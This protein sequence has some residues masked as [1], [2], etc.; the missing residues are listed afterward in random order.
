MAEPIGA[1]RVELSAN[2]AQFEKDMGR[3]RIAARN[4]SKSMTKSFKSVGAS[5]ARTIGSIFS[6]RNALISVGAAAAIGYFIKRQLEAA[7]AIAKMADSVGISTDALQ[8]LQFAFKQL[9]IE[10]QA[11]GGGLQAFNKRLGELRLGTGSLDTILKKLG[12]EGFR[13]ALIGARNTEQAFDIL[14]DRL[15]KAK[16]AQEAA[17]IAGAAL[18][19]TLGAKFVSAARTGVEG[20]NRLRQSARDLGLVIEE[21]L[22]R[23]AEKANDQLELMGKALST[24][25]TR[26]VIALAP[27][28]IKLGQA[29]AEALPHIV[30]FVG[31]LLPDSVAPIEE[32]QTRLQSLREEALELQIQLA[33]RADFLNEATGAKDRIV[34]IDAE[35]RALESLIAKRREENDLINATLE[36]G[37]E[38]SDEQADKIEKIVE[39]L[40][41]EI[42]QLHRTENGQKLYTLAKTAGIEVNQAFTDKVLPLVAALEAEKKAQDDAT[43]AAKARE[44]ALREADSAEIERQFAA[45]NVALER[46]K[47]LHDKNREAVDALGLTFS[48]RFEEAALAGA[49]LSDVLQGLADDIL[50]LF[51]RQLIL[52]PILEAATGF[53]GDLFP[54]AGDIG[55]VQSQAKIDVGTL[56]F[57]ASGGKHRGGFRVVGEN[58]PELEATGPSRIYSAEETAEIMR[59][60]GGGGDVTVNVYAPPG[61][62]V[63]TRERNGP[64]GR[65]ID[66]ILDEAMAKAINSPGSRT[67]KAFSSRFGAQPTLKGRG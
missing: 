6:L 45:Q 46:Q 41:F 20:I 10:E 12:D 53:L 59:G 11:L 66:V 30:R 33:K 39:N 9:G 21:S 28:I 57:F 16:D 15:D 27:E 4:S 24:Q 58:G 34:E 37:G 44:K 13:K 8:E 50:K 48:S 67:A 52:K 5:V 64:G 54:G 14:I 17:A 22:L 2:A 23:E 26:A 43:D 1:L 51:L 60:G 36:S 19:R 31:S 3:A 25:V 62:S 65:S 61:S 35:I 47:D 56:P 38:A 7:D 32:L 49:K 55:A 40:Q 18:G 63:E 29:F 42:D